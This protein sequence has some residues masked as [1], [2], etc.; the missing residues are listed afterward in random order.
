MQK[1]PENSSF[2]AH[3]NNKSAPSFHGLQ[4]RQNL[5]FDVLTIFLPFFEISITY[6]KIVPCDLFRVLLEQVTYG[7]LLH[8]HYLDGVNIVP[9]FTLNIGWNQ[10]DSYGKNSLQCVW[11]QHPRG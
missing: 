6:L 5:K 3:N 1:N 4:K 8:I 7:A 11:A 2:D 10:H 9:N